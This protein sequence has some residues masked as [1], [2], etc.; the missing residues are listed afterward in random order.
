MK[1]FKKIISA[2][3]L[4]TLLATAA[5]AATGYRVIAY[6]DLGMHCA[7]PTFAGFLLLPPFNTIRANVYRTGGVDPVY[8]DDLTAAAQ[9]LT[10]SYS[11]VENTDA[12]L[13]ADPY[14]SS[15]I[16]NAPKLFPGFAPVNAQGNVVGLTGKK[17]ADTMNYDATAF[18][19]VAA[20]IPAYPVTTGDVTKDI[21]TDP[22]GGPKRD[23]FITANVY[24]K[25]STGAVLGQTSTV[26]P[27]AF[28]GCCT[29]HI[30]LAQ[31]N[32]YPATPAGSFAYLGKLHGLNA[33][34]VDFSY[35]D[36]DGDG[37]GGPIRCSWCHLDPAMG[38][39]VAPGVPAGYRILPGATFTA[40]D[41][42]VSPRTFS[43]VLHKYHT[44]NA[45]VLTQFD[46]NIAKNCYDCHPGNGVNCYRGSHKG[47]TAIWCT[48][49]HG[50]LNQR[51]A[52][53][54]LIKPW[55]QTT[56]PS[57]YNP[58]PGITSAFPCH[59]ST[60]YPTFTQN[61][62]LFGKYLNARGHVDKTLCTTCHG[63]PHAE[64]PSTMSLDNV[65]N[66]TLQGDPNYTFP[67]GKDKTYA[68]GVC[69][70]CHV[71]RTA[72]DTTWQVPPHLQ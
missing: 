68:L 55:D 45:K 19:W 21:M 17:L 20:G 15:W 35:I 65:Q 2:L 70:V 67:A 8:I 34:K 28:G 29:C 66:A 10:V 1:S 22:L 25:N 51:V 7:C 37:T 59:S 63:Q 52:T 5:M 12:I 26:V 56:L 33:S 3:A 43:D 47:K 58:S 38:E 6:N 60:T 49:C 64:Q 61:P 31:Q 13:K 27:V 46:A 72:S 36:P 48:D 50:D 62:G 39:S 4:V 9:G 44:Q 57:C 11:L 41:V 16:T 32:G 18:G 30:P 69:A 53:N 23:P 24:L 40:A 54:Q 14:F 71:G 42:K